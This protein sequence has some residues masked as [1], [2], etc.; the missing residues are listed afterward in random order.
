[1]FL[2]MGDEFLTELINETTRYEALIDANIST[3]LNELT[4]ELGLA[5]KVLNYQ[6]KMLNTI[7]V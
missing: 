3:G 1:M 7:V 4:E 6:Q 5:T 2:K